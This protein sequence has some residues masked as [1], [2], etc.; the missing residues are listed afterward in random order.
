MEWSERVVGGGWGW[1]REVCKV[2]W[3]FGGRILQ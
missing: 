2:V 1:V 3:F